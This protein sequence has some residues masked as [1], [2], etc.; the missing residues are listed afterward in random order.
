MKSSSSKQFVTTFILVLF[1]AAAY[2]A[3]VDM[4]DPRRALGRD[5]DIRIDAELMQDTVASNSTIAVTYQIENHSN[6]PVAIADKLSDASYDPDTRTIVLSIGSE[7]PATKTIPHLALINPGEKRVLTTGA[8]V[9]V[10]MPH[11]S[12][13]FAAVPQFV[14]ILVN[15]LR[16][17]RPFAEAI[18]HQAKNSVAELPLGNDLF[19]QWIQSND[20]IYLNS[21]PIRWKAETRDMA[22]AD[23]SGRGVD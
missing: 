9:H 2:A 1:A 6:A 8:T 14:K 12:S 13:P 18:A 19:D 7:I 17:L 3:H 23:V 5:D 11:V 16:D 10:A 21:I 15:V 22:G 20:S 4:K